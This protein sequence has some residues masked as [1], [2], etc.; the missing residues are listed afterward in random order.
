MS[1]M[2]C[3]PGYLDP[4][5][6]QRLKEHKY[7]AA[8]KSFLEPYMQIFWTKLIDY[9]P[10]WMAPNLIT[11][12]GLLVNVVTVLVLVYFNPD[13]N[14][15]RE[16]PSWVY[17]LCAA[18]VFFYQ[19]LDALDGKQAR[20]TGSASPLGELF[21]HGCDAV[22]TIFL[23]LALCMALQLGPLAILQ[24]LIVSQAIFYSAHW[25]AY[26]TGVMNFGSVD[27]T[28]AH[29]FIIT[30]HLLTAYFGPGIWATEVLNFSLSTIAAGTLIMSSLMSF[31]SNVN[32]CLEGGVGREGTSVAETSVASPAIPLT[33][34]I[35]GYLYISSFDCF[36]QVPM[37]VVF[38]TGMAL[39]KQCIKIVVCHMSK[40]PMEM[41][42]LTLTIP[43]IFF[44]EQLLGLG[45]DSLLLLSVV[46]LVNLWQ[47]GDYCA[48]VIKEICT[49]LNISCFTIP[50]PKTDK[51]E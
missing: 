43:L 34:G 36:V 48:S 5:A 11:A 1:S 8:G 12:I 50:S 20:R 4:P 27:V 29:M 46:A 17:V 30:V 33:L 44:F 49:Y 45:F 2:A 25:R 51:T 23:V 42:D 19:T 22:S 35:V 31:F 38:V 6:L 28:E 10:L 37:L 14:Y 7:S 18:G 16:V 21:D 3:M 47:L 32:V 26:V 24:C 41:L 40:T 39:S 15:D 13:F 9:V